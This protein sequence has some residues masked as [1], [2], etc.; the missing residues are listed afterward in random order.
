MAKENRDRWLDLLFSDEIEGG[1]SDRP[2]ADDP[3]RQTMRGIT[4]G[5]YRDYCGRED[6]TPD[7][8]RQITEETARDI[9]VTLFW[10]PI[11]A[12]LLP[13]GVDI[14]AA[15]F[16]FNSGWVRAAKVLQELVGVKV[17]GF[18]GPDTITAVRKLKPEDVVRDY[19]DARLEFLE[20]LKNWSANA[21]GWRKRVRLMRNAALKLAP[22]SP[23]LDEAAGSKIVV[24][25]GAAALP[26]FTV[27]AWVWNNVGPRVVEFLQHPENLERLQ[28]GVVS[29][30]SQT[31]VVHVLAV[32]SVML[33]VNLGAFGFIGWKRMHM[34]K[35]GRV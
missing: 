15:D 31:T 5:C 14:M 13:P 8:L 28:S 1:W 6:A 33:A 21:N 30:G 22:S 25:A 9:A 18:V 3:G 11:G 17:D 27:L 32:L 23:M 7:E 19:G 4:I 24:T 12:D 29:I 26:S 34:W 10:N 20:D 35:A 2:A 16:A